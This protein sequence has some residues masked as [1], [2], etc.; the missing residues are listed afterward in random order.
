MRYKGVF[1]DLDGTLLPVDLGGIY[2]PLHRGPHGKS[3]TPRGT[4]AVSE[5]PAGVNCKNDEQRRLQDQRRGFYGGLLPG[6]TLSPGS[7]CPSSKTSTA[8]NTACLARAS[9]PGPR[10]QGRGTGGGRRRP[11]GAGHQSPFSR[12]AVEVRLEWA[13]LT[14]FLSGILPPMK[15]A[16]NASPILDYADILA[17]PKQGGECLMVGNDTLEDL[18]AGRNWA[19]TPSAGRLSHR[20]RLS[21]CSTWRG[22]W[23]EPVGCADRQ[24]IGRKSKGARPFGPGILP[25]PAPTNLAQEIGAGLTSRGKGPGIFGMPRGVLKR[26]EEGYCFNPGADLIAG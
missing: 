6:G 5:S 10:R 22:G 24:W 12:M 23:G 18:A 20:A 8:G 2:R 11:G 17:A 26:G 13:G 21:P 15:T 4:A 16:G 7:W 3:C 1:F 9:R 14:R 25:A 19:L